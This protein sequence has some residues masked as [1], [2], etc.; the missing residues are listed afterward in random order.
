MSTI[1]IIGTGGM[2]AAIG[3]RT[4]KAGYAVEVISR[5]PA[6]VRVLADKLAAG[7]TTGTHS[8]APAPGTS[9]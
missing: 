8:A 9:P 1:S 6:K 3:G 5:N 7:A 2:A 4:A